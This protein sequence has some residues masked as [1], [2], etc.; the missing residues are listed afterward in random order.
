MGWGKPD[1]LAFDQIGGTPTNLTHDFSM[2]D[3]WV[4]G[5]KSIGVQPLL[6]LAYDPTPLQTRAE[7][8]RWKDLPSDLDAWSAINR[9]YAAHLKNFGADYEIWNEPDMPEPNGKMFFSGDA[10]DYGR[11]YGASIKGREKRRR[12]RFDRR[13]R[14]R[15][16]TWLF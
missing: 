8:A 7:W 10:A 6:A 2:I 14:R 1:V 5:L 12:R 15:L 3:A 9:A 13:A 16:M 4:G 11:L